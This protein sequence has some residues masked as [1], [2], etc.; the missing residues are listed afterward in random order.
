MEINKA[1]TFDDVLLVPKKSNHLP[2][3]SITKTF[4][5][6]DIGLG[7]PII[8]AAMDTVSD[9]RLA[10]AI[11]QLGGI[12]CIHKNMSIEEQSQQIKNV[13]KFE[14]GMVI[15]PITISPDEDISFAIDLMKSNKISGIPVVDKNKKLVGI[16]TNR[17]LRFTKNLKAKVKDLMTKKVITVNEGVNS[18]HA[19]KLLHK[20][21][22][23][24]LVVVN[25]QFKC[26][27]LITVKD[28][29]KSQ[30]FPDASKDKNQSLRVAG[31]IGVN[32]EG[33]NRAEL[34]LESGADALILDTAHGH[35]QSVINTVKNIKKKFK[36]KNLI[37][38]NVA[39][40]DAAKEL[41]DNGAD[42]IK[43]GIGPGSICTTRVVAGVG[44]PQFTAIQNVSSAIK[45]YKVRVIADGGIRY[46]GDI[47]KAIGAGA[48]MV[49]IGSLFAGTDEAPG[50]IF[51]YQGRSYKSYRGMGSL[52]AMARGSADRYFQED[53]KDNLKLVPEGIEGRVP[54]R[55]PVK[56]IINQLVGGLKASMG[57]IGA[58][59]IDEL[60]K[61]AKFVQI[62]NSGLKEGHVHN[63]QIT[64]QSPNY[65]VEN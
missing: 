5:T 18:E 43:V 24:K 48:D 21:R 34:L 33:L 51:Y 37:V 42:T 3:E 12:A 47:A 56:N 15:D 62:T 52:S 58:K 20:Y 49:M 17:D 64:K 25:K 23:E 4:L 41:A 50:E 1:L 8:S 39:T 29:E 6:N 28:L 7:I 44:M 31:A 65:P 13:K 19:K 30:V 45:N 2:A 22:I 57:Y 9:Y 53:I 61:K 46:S 35:S 40:G 60:K 36:F 32:K 14:S 59:T 55:G 63:V 16:I 54:Y 38:G 26:T 27:G 10:I 11:A